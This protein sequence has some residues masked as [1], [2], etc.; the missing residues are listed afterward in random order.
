MDAKWRA[1]MPKLYFSSDDY[2]CFICVSFRM[3]FLLTF[4]FSGY[5]GIWRNKTEQK[6]EH[7]AKTPNSCTLTYVIAWTQII[8][9]ILCIWDVQEIGLHGVVVEVKII[10]IFCISSYKYSF[11]NCGWKDCSLFIERHFGR[12][13]Y[14]WSI[15]GSSQRISNIGK[16]FKMACTGNSREIYR[17]QKH[18]KKK[19][20]KKQQRRL[21]CRPT[22]SAT[23]S[24][25]GTGT[26]SVIFC[27]FFERSSRF[28]SICVN[29]L[30]PMLFDKTLLMPFNPLQS[31]GLSDGDLLLFQ[32]ENQN[33][34]NSIREMM[35]KMRDKYLK[36]LAMHRLSIDFHTNRTVSLSI[37]KKTTIK[38]SGPC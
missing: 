25:L 12:M 7:K 31:F 37:E 10:Q 8:C 35:H 16:F 32:N 17:K 30:K 13:K 34:T 22:I 14:F 21:P 6:T 24:E 26:H 20:R 19:C 9:R 36:T 38:Y 18:T 23:C 1:R 33:K 29:A 2:F 15:G 4:I 3:H 28:G 5:C 27:D 11:M